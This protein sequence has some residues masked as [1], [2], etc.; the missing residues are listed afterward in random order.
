[1]LAGFGFILASCAVH[2]SG[3]AFD[4]DE[5][6][7]GGKKGELTDAEII[8]QYPNQFM[9]RYNGSSSDQFS[10]AAPYS[11]TDFGK[12]DATTGL[13]GGGV[14]RYYPT[15]ID[16]SADTA[17]FS[18]V[19]KPNVDEGQ[20]GVGFVQVSDGKVVGWW[21]VTTH[22]KI[23]Y[24]NPN[25]AVEA[26]KTSENGSGW[27]AGTKK[28]ITSWTTGTEY[29]VKINLK[30]LTGS[31]GDT[32]EKGFEVL[33]Y[34]GDSTT[35]AYEKYAK[36]GRWLTPDANSK[37]YF[38]IGTTKNDSSNTTWSNITAKVNDGETYTMK[39]I[40]DVQ[41]QSAMKVTNDA[42]AVTKSVLLS[43]GKSVTLK[44]SAKDADG[45]DVADKVTATSEDSSIASASVNASAGTFTITAGDTSG[46]TKIVVTNTAGTGTPSVEISVEVGVPGTVKLDGTEKND[47]ASAFAAI[48]DDSDHEITLT[49]GSYMIDVGTF[50]EYKGSGTLK[51]TGDTTADFGA[52]VKIIGDTTGLTSMATRNLVYL[53]GEGNL[54]LK[55]ISID[56][57]PSGS[58]DVQ[59]E[60]LAS[61]GSGHVA[62][63]NCTF[64]SHQDTIR[65]TGKAWFYKCDIYG[66]V[67]FL[68]MNDSG[69]VAL[70]E[71]CILNV[72]GDRTT[73]AYIAAPRMTKKETGKIGKGVVVFN[74][75][76]KVDTGVD[77]YL[78]R[79]PWSGNSENANKY[80]NQ[81]AFVD[82][83]VE[84][85]LNV[86]LEKSGAFGIGDESIVGWKLGGTNTG[87]TAPSGFGKISDA[88]YSAEYSNRG[89]ILNKLITLDEGAF[90]AFKADTAIWDVDTE[91]GWTND[92]ETVEAAAFEANSA[93]ITWDF[94]TYS[95][96]NTDFGL[97]HST[98][99]AYAQLAGEIV[100][101]TGT[102][103]TK[104]KMYFDAAQNYGGQKGR[105]K[106]WADAS[107]GIECYNVLLTV[108]L[109]PGATLSIEGA[110]LSGVVIN[111]TVQTSYKNT[112][113]QSENAVIWVPKTTKAYLFS[114]SVT[115]YDLTKSD[116][117][118]TSEQKFIDVTLDKASI[119]K[120]KTAT[121][122]SIV[123]NTLGGTE[124]GVTWE[125]NPS[126][127][128]TVSNGTVTALEVTDD[129]DV[130]VNAKG[131]VNTAAIGSAIIT[132]KPPAVETSAV[133]HDNT[134]SSLDAVVSG[135]AFTASAA[136][137]ESTLTYNESKLNGSGVVITELNTSKKN[138][139]YVDYT[140]TA[141]KSITVSSIT[142]KCGNHSTGNVDLAVSYYTSNSSELV[143]I[144]SATSTRYLDKTEDLEI[145]VEQGDSITFRVSPFTTASKTW[146]GVTVSL[147]TFSVTA[148]E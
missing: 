118:T 53:N 26:S 146:S 143:E 97:Y 62:A 70:Y 91:L 45:N 98:S 14:F 3:G 7:G 38:A 121:A 89:F 102:E 141:S 110:S 35:A 99:P 130:T 36:Y 71:E 77:A 34:E 116:I 64:K 148:I 54:V 82:V 13:A 111:G 117:P 16:L 65:T 27:D 46:T 5:D 128:A 30:T 8:E 60:A 101:Y 133:W 134:T 132:V 95:T 55:N 145:V 112:G 43:A 147:G 92:T 18:A 63:Y 78:F 125:A 84:G 126:T 81:A 109:T 56:N 80:Y 33:V 6:N 11:I 119:R 37:I 74:S 4:K 113:S 73:S 52:D 2:G 66:D 47:V 86:A 1:M 20:Q 142:A 120:D 40:V 144:F 68:W 139:V 51:I 57:R 32:G 137:S 114:V 72:V 31:T 108:P 106:E 115:K 136:N 61:E 76:I 104:P 90:E 15:A 24:W 94:S 48:T 85:T 93:E 58:S 12:P 138:A 42:G 105:A 44:I 87:V 23:R 49:S 50:L 19:V 100:G 59:A 22:N 127:A 88:D 135:S 25:N 140:I 39:K 17:E 96:F 67:D 83:K 28:D 103:Y 41:D 124:Q 9:F 75:T 131:A 79:N 107:H 122:T 29:T 21:L 10:D 69:V 123:I 129:T